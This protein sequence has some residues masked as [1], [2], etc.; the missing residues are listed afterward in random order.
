MEKQYQV[1]E[2]RQPSVRVKEKQAYVNKDN[3]NEQQ[4]M[5]PRLFK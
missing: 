1:V 5:R 4:Q 3:G 2:A